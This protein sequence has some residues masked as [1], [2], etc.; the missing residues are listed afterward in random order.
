VVCSTLSSNGQQRC[1]SRH[2]SK[3][4]G[5]TTSIYMPI[6]NSNGP[7]ARSGVRTPSQLSKSDQMI[8]VAERVTVAVTKGPTPCSVANGDENPSPGV[9]AGDPGLDRPHHSNATGVPD[10]AAT[11][12]VSQ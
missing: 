8:F 9:A 11:P 6:G 3:H 1:I 5:A 7:A 2:P 10:D 4:I 12:L